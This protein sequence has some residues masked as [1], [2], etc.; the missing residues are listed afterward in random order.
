SGLKILYGEG[1][2]EVFA[3][4]L[5]E[6][7]KAGHQVTTAQGRKPVEEALRKGSFDFAVLGGSLSR[8]DRHHLP[9]MIRKV[10]QA[11]KIVVMH[12]DGERHPYVD[13]NIDTG[14]DMEHL[15]AKIAEVASGA[16]KPAMAKGAAA[17]K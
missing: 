6:M 9:Y 17:G 16:T 10:S 15:L 2:A 5:A 4:N 3:S 11:I 1:D 13:G 12:T 14:Q 7:Q 8:N